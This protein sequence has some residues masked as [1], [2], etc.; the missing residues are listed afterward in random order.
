MTATE[1]D[2]ARLLSRINPSRVEIV[3]QQDSV[4]IH[5]MT[6]DG[7]LKTL[8]Q[9]DVDSKRCGEAAAALYAAASKATNVM[10]IATEEA[11]RRGLCIP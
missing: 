9:A 4:K 7:V 6:N 3:G 1:P 5:S 8:Q 11:A 2:L 10:L